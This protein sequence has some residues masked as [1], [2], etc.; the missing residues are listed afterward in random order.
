[1]GLDWAIFVMQH[2]AVFV[3]AAT[4][5]LA[6]NGIAQSMPPLPNIIIALP[7]DIPSEKVWVQYVL[8]SSFGAHGSNGVQEP[9]SHRIEIL[10]AVEG[11]RA[12]EM[13]VFV[14]ASGCKIVTF[15]I[16]IRGSSDIHETFFCSPLSSITLVGQIKNGPLDGTKLAEV[17]VDYL[18]G[19]AC[20]FFGFLDCMVPQVSLGTTNP[21]ALGIF[22]IDVPDF[23]T[24][25]I[26][27]SSSGGAE[28]Q[29]VL[30]EVKTWN[31]IAF[32]E[33]ESETLR[34]PSSALKVVP[35]YP[36]NLAFLTRKVN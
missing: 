29:L 1:M 5:L 9:G 35:S 36:P 3:V 20:G 7:A 15:D 11:K 33:P 19:W 30:R 28:F 25:P 4:A 31:L 22:E 2:L 24:D 12:H 10:G 14:W 34:T 16:P 27:S 13:K 17:R 18:A 6:E 8:Y 26:S 32:L 23:S 21:D